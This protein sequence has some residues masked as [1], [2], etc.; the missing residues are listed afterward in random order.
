MLRLAARHADAWHIWLSNQPEGLAPLQEAVDA[1]CVAVGRDPTTLERSVGV[2]AD[3][4]GDGVWPLLHEAGAPLLSGSPEEMAGALKDYARAGLT[5]VD[6]WLTPNTLAGLEAFAPVL[7]LLD[8]GQS[9]TG[10]GH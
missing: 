1:A 5:R 7:E 4:T 3:L 9:I 8:R 6:V 2:V 10:E